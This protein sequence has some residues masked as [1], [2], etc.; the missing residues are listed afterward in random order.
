MTVLT[1]TGSNAALLAA[2]SVADGARVTPV[3]AA[4]TA[5]PVRT[6]APSVLTGERT[7]W[8]SSTPSRAALSARPCPPAFGLLPGRLARDVNDRK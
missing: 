8:S 3:A 7:V 6:V 1:S 2:D 5:T 4:L